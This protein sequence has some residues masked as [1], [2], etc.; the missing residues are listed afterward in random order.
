M[1]DEI[2]KEQVDKVLKELDRDILTYYPVAWGVPWEAGV[3]EK[4]KTIMAFYE[5]RKQDWVKMLPGI[6]EIGKKTMHAFI[7][8]ADLE[9]EAA[10][11]VIFMITGRKDT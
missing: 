10:K 5:K 4:M 8:M 9:I 3:E 1:S 6:S 2:T 11:D 7:R